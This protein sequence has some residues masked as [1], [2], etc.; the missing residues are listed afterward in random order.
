[1]AYTDTLDVDMLIDTT[2]LDVVVTW[3]ST[4]YD[5]K[6]SYAYNDANGMASRS[7]AFT[8]KESD[9]SAITKGEVI[10]YN[11]INWTVKQVEPDGRGLIRIKVTKNP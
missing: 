3:S 2:A 1:M 8:V 4:S 6:F 10:N 7:P 11:S 9:F 5:A